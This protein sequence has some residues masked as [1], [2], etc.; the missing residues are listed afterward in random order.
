MSEAEFLHLLVTFQD[1]HERLSSIDIYVDTVGII[2]KLGCWAV[3][4]QPGR[5]PFQT[6]DLEPFML[7]YTKRNLNGQFVK[8]Q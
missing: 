4:P 7:T 1:L 2:G 3:V 5:R 6:T 8:V